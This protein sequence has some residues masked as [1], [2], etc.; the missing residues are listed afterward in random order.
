VV[1][2]YRKSDN[3]NLLG[4]VPPALS[5]PAEVRRFLPLS[6]L[7]IDASASTDAD[8]QIVYWNWRFVSG[9]WVAMSNANTSRLTLSGFN[10]EAVN[11]YEVTAVDNRG[12]VSVAQVRVVVRNPPPPGCERANHL[13][14]P[15]R[16]IFNGRALGVQ[17]GDTIWV[18]AGR[19]DYIDL[20]EVVGTASRPVV[21]IN[22]GG[23]AVVG[24]GN[25][26]Y[27]ITLTHCRHIKFTGSG[28][29]NHR[30]GVWVNRSGTTTQ[31]VFG[32][33]INGTSS[34]IEV[35]RVH[36]SQ[37]SQHGFSIKSDPTCDNPTT[38]RENFVMRNINLHHNKVD[39]TGTEG[40]YLGFTGTSRNCNGVNRFAHFL[41]NVRIWENDISNTGNDGIQPSLVD[42][43][44]LIHNNR[45]SNIGLNNTDI[46][47]EGIIVG[48]GSNGEV[49]NNSIR[50]CGGTGVM[51][52]GQNIK[53]YNN[54]IEAADGSYFNFRDSNGTGSYQVYNNTFLR[55]TTSGNAAIY[56]D[57]SGTGSLANCFIRNNLIIYKVTGQAIGI[58]GNVTT[59]TSVAQSNNLIYRSF[60][61]AM[62][63][64][65]IDNFAPRASSPA[66]D[67]GATIAGLIADHASTP[68]P[69][70]TNFDVGAYEFRS[71]ATNLLPVVGA[72][73]ARTFNLPLPQGGVVLV[74]TASD[75]DG[76]IASVL[77]EQ[78]SGP[79]QAQL[80]NANTLNLSIRQAVRGAYVFRLT[81]TDNRGASASAQVTV[82]FNQPP[83]IAPF[84]GGTL[85]L[86]TTSTEFAL[87]ISDID[88]SVASIACEQVFGP[89]TATIAGGTTANPRLSGL[90]LPG[91][92]R[93]AI[94]ATDNLGA[95]GSRVVSVQVNRALEMMIWGPS[96][97]MLP[98]A[99]VA[100]VGMANSPDAKIQSL[101]WS[102][103]SGPNQAQLVNATT[104]NLTARALVQGT[105]VFRLR[106]T[107]TNG[108]SATRDFTLAV[109]PSFGVSGLQLMNNGAA[110]APLANGATIDYSQL[111]VV[112]IS[113]LNIRAQV[114]GAVASVR[115]VL[116]N[117]T[118]NVEVASD[119]N[120]PFT[121]YG[122][123]PNSVWVLI[124][125]SY[126]L[127]VT[128][129]SGANLSGAEGAPVTVN[130]TVA[131]NAGNIVSNRAAPTAP[132][133]EAPA[134]SDAPAAEI[135]NQAPEA[136]PAGVRLEGL[137]HNVKE[138]LE[139]YLGQGA[140]VSVR[141][142]SGR[143][144]LRASGSGDQASLTL[145]FEQMIV[146]QAIYVYTIVVPG[147][148]QAIMGRF[149]VQK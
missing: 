91:I 124:P 117:G 123:N 78:V 69:Q 97:I 40:M 44:L 79:S 71:A 3:L 75:P 1:F 10:G 70:G 47:N 80:A 145:L 38:W 68:R 93:F 23:Q 77:W 105:Y 76:S 19:Y 107:D 37:V 139:R 65:S 34:D 83:V 98:T 96:A 133:S 50:R 63:V 53:V 102:Q 130:F 25:P 100:L 55:L 114:T 149:V 16:S 54:V 17:P 5:V 35:E 144:L 66:I 36:V 141:D 61:P 4:N 111:G 127:T 121:L 103:V 11:T 135:A 140:V 125:G 84:S 49:F 132:A 119:N 29:A 72:G 51:S 109:V 92:Y 148:G 28:S 146:P 15:P 89:T 58:S 30:Y 26:S 74:G 48:G 81:A 90:T 20:V 33:A 126:R 85:T 46:H 7:V 56:F 138:K 41:R 13:I 6:S 14:A 87:R 106:A 134:I 95:V 9:N 43:V 137:E 18:G 136:G 24:R 57:R 32:F 59:A 22:C 45:L 94:R 128:P 147:E 112:N 8:G 108:A 104:L 120:A 129:Y 101:A 73:S 131:N 122:G 39:S 27:G 52:F 2:A 31:P 62:L 143:E 115:F 113:L 142:A 12:G 67:A 86:P 21:V 42:S 64:D 88:G 60:A 118:R 110:L 82:N 116:N 99:Q